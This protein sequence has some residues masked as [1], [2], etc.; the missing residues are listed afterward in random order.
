[1][2]D[3]EIFTMSQRL[4]RLTLVVAVSLLVVMALAFHFSTF[5]VKQQFRNGM[6]I[7]LVHVFSPEE[8][9]YL[10]CDLAANKVAIEQWIEIN[11]D[12][13]L[14]WSKSYTMP[15][16]EEYGGFSVRM[17]GPG[18]DKESGKKT[19]S[20]IV[21]MMNDSVYITFGPDTSHG[22]WTS[23]R[24]ATIEEDFLLSDKLRNCEQR[25]TVSRE[26]RGNNRQKADIKG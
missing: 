9:G 4:K 17:D 2:R 20:I 26:R 1:M 12:R 18:I 14:G 16:S 24:R 6:W 7:E 15:P 19:S 5:Q 8:A 3:P 21:T 23:Y 25:H 13:R 10:N 11:F 22:L